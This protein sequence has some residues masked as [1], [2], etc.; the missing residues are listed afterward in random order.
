MQHDD[1]QVLGRG[2]C[3]SISIRP[4]TIQRCEDVRLPEAR[5]VCGIGYAVAAPDTARDREH[6]CQQRGAFA[7]L[8]EQQGEV[9]NR[10]KPTIGAVFWRGAKPD[11][12]VDAGTDGTLPGGRDRFARRQAPDP[13]QALDSGQTVRDQNHRASG[14]HFIQRR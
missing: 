10:A 7:R 4:N 8:C 1:Q 12:R 11:A 6:L 2:R 14:R 3:V 13:I 9:I 5:A